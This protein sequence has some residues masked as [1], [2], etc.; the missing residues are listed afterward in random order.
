[1]VKVKKPK[2]PNGL[3]PYHFHGVDL[4]WIE[5]QK[6]A[7]GD[8]PFCGTENKFGVDV[9]SSEFNCYKP[10][11]GSKGNA[12]T[13]VEQLWE[14][15]YDR[16]NSYKELQV[17]RGI[18]HSDTF[19]HWNVAWSAWTNTWIIP[20][21]SPEMRIRQLYKFK[22]VKGKKRL[23]AT[24]TLGHR[25]FGLNLYKKSDETI[26][27]CEGPWDAMCLWEH[28]RVTKCVDGK[29]QET[30]NT[31][32]SLLGG[33]C[34]LAIPGCNVFFDKWTDL[35]AGKTVNIM[36]DNDHPSEDPKTGEL[37]DSASIKGVK[38]I[39]KI[40]SQ[41]KKPPKEIIYDPWNGSGYDLDSPDGHDLRDMLSQ[42][43]C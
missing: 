18:K 24:P 39:S 32:D 7:Q 4:T 10:S 31:N 19:M 13:F 17:D 30:A 6:N 26:Y 1:M 35:F 3:R 22:T 5:G 27:L 11:C 12:S 25:I 33:A 2:M 43:P 29:Y 28:L 16:T 42:A 21:Y 9:K 37:K 14:Y 20:G 40:L 38:R 36:F 41:A 34:V 23:L 8:C 15:W